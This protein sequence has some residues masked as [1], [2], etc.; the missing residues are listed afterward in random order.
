MLESVLS[1][2]IIFES[3]AVADAFDGG[4]R[5]CRFLK[6]LMSLLSGI[7][8]VLYQW[9]GGNH[10]LYGYAMCDITILILLITLALFFWP[11]VL[12]RFGLY[13][14]RVGD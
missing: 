14:R 10:L 5:L 3:F 4:D 9:L 7:C 13:K 11:R 6:Y 2:F 1:V 8:V 12:S